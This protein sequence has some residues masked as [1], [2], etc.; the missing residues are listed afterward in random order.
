[1]FT[2]NRSVLTA[3]A[4]NSVIRGH[5]LKHLS[6]LVEEQGSATVTMSKTQTELAAE[7]GVEHSA[8]TQELRAMRREG[9]ID[10]KWK[11]FTLFSLD[12]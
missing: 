12:S 1:M 5:I 11:T 3:P 2:L 9:I 6:E 4:S 8:L 7:L 10:Y